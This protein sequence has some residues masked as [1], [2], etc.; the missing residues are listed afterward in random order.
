ML[1]RGT[2]VFVLIGL[3][4]VMQYFIRAQITKQALKHFY[5]FD[6][7]NMRG[8]IVGKSASQDRERF[9]LNNLDQEFVFKSKA[10]E[11]NG[12]TFFYAVAE[13]G[14]S[15]VKPSHADTLSLIKANSHKVI[16]Y[17]FRKW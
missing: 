9:R 17:T 16:Y 7:T 2:I 15:V 14:D 1:K 13:V 6:S 12:F 8:V 10:T 4:I 11:I 3:F 5:S